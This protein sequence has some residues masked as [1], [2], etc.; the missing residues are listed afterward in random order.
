MRACGGYHSVRVAVGEH[1]NGRNERKGGFF[2]FQAEDGIRDRNVTGVQTCALPISSEAP[3][4]T[5]GRPCS[6]I[7]LSSTVSDDWSPAGNTF[8]LAR[9]RPSS[10]TICSA[11]PRSIGAVSWEIGRASCRERV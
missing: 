8:R 6:V 5:E 3:I 9:T 4:F 1:E 10:S 2:V 7:N 11:R